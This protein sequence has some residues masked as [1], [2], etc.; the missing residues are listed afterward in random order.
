M[1]QLISAT[2]SEEAA[3]I[4]NNWEKQKKSDSNYDQIKALQTQKS[5]NQ[6]LLSNAMIALHIK[7]PQHPLCKQLNEALE[8]TIYYQYWD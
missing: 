7:D 2:L 1:K 3:K 4:Y 5:Y 8:G 6:R